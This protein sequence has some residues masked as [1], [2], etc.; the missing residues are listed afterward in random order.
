MRGHLSARPNWCK[1]GPEDVNITPTV[2]PLRGTI[3]PKGAFTGYPGMTKHKP[4]SSGDN[5]HDCLLFE[6]KK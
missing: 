6:K 4:G 2:F 3:S 1:T 5:V